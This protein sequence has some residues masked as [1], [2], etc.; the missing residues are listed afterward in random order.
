MIGVSQCSDD[1]WRQRMNKE[2]ETELIFHADLSLSIRQANA[3][4]EIQCAQIDSFIAEGVDLL[5]VCPNEAVEVQPA[6][7]RAYRA[8]IPVI[9]ADRRV[10]GSNWTA[11]VGGDNLQVGQSLGRWLVN[12]Q[13]KQQKPLKVLEVSGLTKSTPAVA[14]HR[15]LINVTQGNKMIEIQSVC[16]KWFSEPA[17]AATDS[18]LTT[19]GHPDIIIAHNDLMA[20][21]AAQACNRH[22]LNIPILGV[23]A[24]PGEG[25]GLEAIL[26]GD[27]TASAYYPSRGD[28]I[29]QR[30]AAILQGH[31]YP[32]ETH[33]NTFLVDQDMAMAMQEMHNIIDDEI[34]DLYELQGKI[35]TLRDQQTLHKAWIY[36]LVSLLI[37]LCVLIVGGYK[38][39]HYRARVKREREEQETLVRHQQEQL[40]R[41]TAELKQTQEAIPAEEVFINR[42][43]QDIEQHL[44]DPELDVESLSRRLGMSRTVLFRKTKAAMG[45]S[46][47]ELIHHIRLHK[48]NELLEKTDLTVQEVAYSVGFSTAGYFTK[49]YKAEFGKLPKQK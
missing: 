38:V 3:N 10:S 41:I 7:T 31:D 26:N 32:R 39:I 35:S 23:D 1:A 45:Q 40:N 48:A 16:G 30:A 25:G 46:P 21:G 4:S 33:L 47:I 29:I 15:G 17:F 20:I 37:A 8:G 12:Y 6:V 49:L 43:K 19:Q 18:F 27:I 2:M 9:V 22:N 24:I 36:T 14:R 11:F 28:I 34:Q 5:V 42:L 13:E 44:D